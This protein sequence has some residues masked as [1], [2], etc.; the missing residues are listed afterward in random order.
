MASERTRQRKSISLARKIAILERQESTSPSTRPK[1][2]KTKLNRH[3]TAM[4]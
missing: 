1:A 2:L 3:I 4:A